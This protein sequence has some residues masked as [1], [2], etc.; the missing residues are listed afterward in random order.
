MKNISKLTLMLC[1]VLSI[2]ACKKSE[3]VKATTGAA[4]E[5]AVITG[6]TFTLNT[7]ASQ[8]IWEGTKPTG[9]HTGTV[10][11]TSGTISV[12]DG[13]ISGGQFTMDMNSITSTDLTGDDKLYLES[14]LKGTGDGNQDD[15]FNVTKF[16]TA[17]FEITKVTKLMNNEENTHLVYGNLTLR[18][19]TKEIG[20]NAN[21]TMDQNK[22]VV[23]TPKFKI[24][25]TEWGV[26]FKSKKIFDDLKDKFI[27]D[28]IGLKISVVATGNPS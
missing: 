16:P 22:I 2:V 1:I 13:M 27:N 11:I 3:G 12:E 5:A 24:D 4:A 6:K 15:F 10:N 26:N 14:H 21:V 19:V 9:S 8:L 25:R 23:V 17:K 28:E 20:F 18:D 7:N